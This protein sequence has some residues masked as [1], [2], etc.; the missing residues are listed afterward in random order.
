MASKRR[1]LLGKG[2]R[3]CCYQLSDW[4]YVGHYWSIRLPD[5]G[6]HDYDAGD[7]MVSAHFEALHHSTGLHILNRGGSAISMLSDE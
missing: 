7:L 4:V 5:F 6:D 1:T 2:L 3:L